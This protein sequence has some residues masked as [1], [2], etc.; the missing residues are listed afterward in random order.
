M[1]KRMDE[2]GFIAIWTPVKAYL[3]KAQGMNLLN[4]LFMAQA[5]HNG[6]D[7]NTAFQPGKLT[8]VEE[9]VVVTTAA[10]R[11]IVIKAFQKHLQLIFAEMASYL[12][13]ND[14][15]SFMSYLGENAKNL[16]CRLGKQGTMDKKV[17]RAL[18]MD[19]LA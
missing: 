11:A 9:Q 17:E 16:A 14:I 12:S 1:R 5:F 19:L 8:T 15:E 10:D 6:I 7:L 13:D 18:K 2:D 4:K 3:C